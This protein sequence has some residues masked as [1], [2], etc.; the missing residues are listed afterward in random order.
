MC[1]DDT[2]WGEWVFQSDLSRSAH[3]SSPIPGPF[4]VT[5]G[6]GEEHE[7]G[8]SY[9]STTGMN[10]TGDNLYG[11]LTIAVFSQQTGNRD[12]EH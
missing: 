12:D 4:P 9:H 2:S 3:Y 1:S 8:L 5:Q 10:C 11:V 6:K 7:A